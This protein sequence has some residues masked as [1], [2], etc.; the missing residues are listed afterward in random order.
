M[1]SDEDR[2]VN[3]LLARWHHWASDER[4]ARGYRSVSPA[5]V[6]FRASRQY[7]DG[8]GALDVDVEDR[9]MRGIDSIVEAIAQPFQTALQINARILCTG[10]AVW[11]SPRLPQDELARAFLVSDARALLVARLR[12]AGLL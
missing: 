1:I 8:N 6:Q 11:R 4:T 3:D 5:F 2:I 10:A 12:R 7:D 9:L